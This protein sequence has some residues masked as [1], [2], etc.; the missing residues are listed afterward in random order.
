VQGYKTLQLIY[1]F[2]AGPDEVKAWTIQ[3]RFFIFLYDLR[4][5][6][7]NFRKEQK[8]PKLLEESTQTL[9]KA[10]LWQK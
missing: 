4:F 9:K 8:L 2:T 5:K 10:L 6:K 3:V 7:E 1:F